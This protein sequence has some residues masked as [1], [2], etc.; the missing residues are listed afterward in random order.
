[1]ATPEE[2]SNFTSTIKPLQERLFHQ[3]AKLHLVQGA[4]RF[5]VTSGGA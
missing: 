1:M 4:K 3:D 2:K 5:N